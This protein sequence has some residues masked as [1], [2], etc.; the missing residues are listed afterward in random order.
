MTGK[1]YVYIL[2]SAVR[3]A[4]YVGQTSDIGSRLI[5]HN[6]GEVTSTKSGIP[7]E[8]IFNIVCLS[9]SEAMQEERKFKNLKSQ[10]KILLRIQKYQDRTEST[11]VDSSVLEKLLKSKI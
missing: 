11:V 2:Y 3:D 6:R 1:Y 4:F 5:R 8:L 9:R 7:W 10:K